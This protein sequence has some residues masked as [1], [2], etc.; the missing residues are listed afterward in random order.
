MSKY[1]QYLYVRTVNPGH[2]TDEYQ[3]SGTV[4]GDVSDDVVGDCESLSP[5]V[6]RYSLVGT[7]VIH[8]TAPLYVEDNAV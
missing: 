7:G 1:S 3:I 2:P 5:I 6:A 4:P 8:H